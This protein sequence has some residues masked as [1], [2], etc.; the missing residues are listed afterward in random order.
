MTPGDVT[1]MAA[2]YAAAWSAGDP[3]GVAAFFAE[4]GRIVINGGE[5][6]IGRD[7]VSAMAAGF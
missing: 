5:P 3:N 1:T 6:H 7:A 4:D 2:R